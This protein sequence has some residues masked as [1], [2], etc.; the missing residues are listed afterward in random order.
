MKAHTT[1]KT[2]VSDNGIHCISKVGVRVLLTLEEKKMDP[3]ILGAVHSFAS[4]DNQ[5]Y[6]WTLP[7]SEIAKPFQQAHTKAKVS[8]R[9][10]N[11]ALYL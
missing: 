4:S 11:Q 6:R 3:E 5:L 10:G 1:Q 9:I 2:F 8:D 7:D